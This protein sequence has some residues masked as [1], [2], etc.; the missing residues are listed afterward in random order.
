SDPHFNHTEIICV[1]FDR[2]GLGREIDEVIGQL[3]ANIVE[4]M[5]AR[6]HDLR[7][8]D[9]TLGRMMVI[10]KEV[11]VSETDERPLD[12]AAFESLQLPDG[13][14]MVDL[15]KELTKHFTLMRRAERIEP[16]TKVGQALRGLVVRDNG[17]PTVEVDD[18]IGQ[19]EE[20]TARTAED[21]PIKIIALDVDGTLAESKKAKITDGRRIAQ[22]SREG[23]YLIGILTDRAFFVTV[24]DVD[25]SEEIIKAVKDNNPVYVDLA[26]ELSR[27]GVTG[28]YED[29]PG[30]LDFIIAGAIA[31]AGVEA[32]IYRYYYVRNRKTNKVAEGLIELDQK[33]TSTMGKDFS[34]AK[35]LDILYRIYNREFRLIMVGD[36]VRLDHANI[37]S[38]RLLPHIEKRFGIQ[39]PIEREIEGE[40]Y[41]TFD[42][43][44]DLRIP[45]PENAIEQPRCL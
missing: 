29:F 38:S 5:E 26:A 11:Q 20:A 12:A 44:Y 40:R 3:N 31:M 1:G 23:D 35:V 27:T 34:M 4:G 8:D 37:L 32:K 25:N 18:L 41:L 17:Y 13:L 6:L 2:K 28:S 7:L 36:S 19:S 39:V 14:V 45:V 43:N 10:H 16:V 24:E 9:R 33:D 21:E 15:G 22:R 42:N 30:D